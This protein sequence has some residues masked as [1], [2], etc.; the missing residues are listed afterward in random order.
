MCLL[1]A[2]II[3]EMIEETMEETL[4]EE[5]LEEEAQEAVDKIL[6]EV[7]AGKRI[8]IFNFLNYS[9]LLFNLFRMNNYYNN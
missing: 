3:E 6:W 2:G 9:T 7:T 1:Q 4:G 8:I 5:D